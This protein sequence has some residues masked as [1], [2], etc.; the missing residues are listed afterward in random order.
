MAR[1]RSSSAPARPRTPSAADRHGTGPP[2]AGDRRPRPVDGQAQRFETG[3]ELADG[4]TVEAG[5]LHRSG[6]SGLRTV[7]PDSPA[8]ESVGIPA[9]VL[10]RLADPGLTG[11]VARPA[12]GGRGGRATPRPPGRRRVPG[13][14]LRSSSSRS[15]NWDGSSRH[16]SATCI[17]YW[18]RTRLS[19]CSATAAR[20]VSAALARPRGTQLGGVEDPLHPEGQKGPGA[21][22]G[23]AQGLGIGAGQ[24]PGVRPAGR[25]AT[26]TSISSR[27][28]HS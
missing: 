22:D 3:A 2:P 9:V 8:V 20:A 21:L 15:R 11:V 16:R 23:G 13:P 6:R 19:G 10:V 27:R 7:G 12:T 24:L 18:S 17:R 28:S 4:A 26:A 25:A 14:S 5:L 1:W